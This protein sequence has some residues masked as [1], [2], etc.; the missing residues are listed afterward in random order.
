M[1]GCQFPELASTT[2]YRKGCRCDDCKAAYSS[3]WKKRQSDPITYA[4]RRLNGIRTHA[5]REGYLELLATPEQVV[6]WLKQ[7]HCEFCLGSLPAVSDRVLHHNHTT[8][9]FVCISCQ[10]CNIVEGHLATLDADALERILRSINN[11][12]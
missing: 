1:K 12:P 10:K 7:D 8:G 4:K 9:D 2:G 6:E 3:S 5:K 11:N